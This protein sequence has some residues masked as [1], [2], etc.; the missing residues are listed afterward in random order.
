MRKHTLWTN[1]N[2]NL[3]DWKADILSEYP[4]MDEDECYALMHEINDTYLDDERGN[5]RMVKNDEEIVVLAD[6]GLWHGRVPG[7]KELNSTCLTDCLSVGQYDY[8]TYYVDEYGEFMCEDIHHDGT[9][10]YIF[11]AWKPGTEDDRENFL[12]RF[13]DGL[14]DGAEIDAMTE[15]LG[16]K[17]AD[18]YGWRD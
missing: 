1:H 3:D 17:I 13:I 18:F 14:A 15:K 10:R 5:L 8:V 9:N 4:D 11:R 16:P 2:L 6:L 12:M 7:Y